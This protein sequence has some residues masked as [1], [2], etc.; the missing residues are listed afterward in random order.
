MGWQRLVVTLQLK[1]RL[2]LTLALSPSSA[3]GTFSRW[4]KERR[5]NRLRP[6]WTRSPECYSCPA[7]KTTLPLLGGEGWGEDERSFPN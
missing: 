4:E 5:G 7:L 6:P 2:A 3:F 1:I